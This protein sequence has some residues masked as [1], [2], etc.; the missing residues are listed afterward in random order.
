MEKHKE[1]HYFASSALHWRVSGDICDL[2]RK[3]DEVGDEEYKVYRVP[4]PLHATYDIIHYVPV[5][6]GIETL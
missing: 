5:V 4:L 1:Y 3:M 6:E 2:V